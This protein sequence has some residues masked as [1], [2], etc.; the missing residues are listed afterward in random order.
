MPQAN[1]TNRVALYTYYLAKQGQQKVRTAL[2]TE[3][4]WSE[5]YLLVYSKGGKVEVRLI[6]Q[7]LYCYNNL[8]IK[9]IK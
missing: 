5:E 8:A 9:E 4:N 1:K 7:L 3:T 6:C 2:K